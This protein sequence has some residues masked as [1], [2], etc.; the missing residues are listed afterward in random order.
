MTN[1]DA[2]DPNAETVTFLYKFGNG[3]CPKSYGFNV[4]KLG[5]IPADVISCGFKKCKQLE[6]LSKNRKLFREFFKSGNTPLVIADLISKVCSV[7]A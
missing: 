3:V 2:D 4:A 1:P 6:D 5:G 7:L